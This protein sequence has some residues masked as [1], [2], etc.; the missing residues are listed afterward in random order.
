MV[1]SIGAGLHV[2]W[3]RA[4][5]CPLPLVAVLFWPFR[6]MGKV[7]SVVEDAELTSQDVRDFL[8]EPS[9]EGRASLAE[10]LARRFDPSNLSVSERD[11]A[12][13]IS[14]LNGP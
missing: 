12:E 13:Q 7:G 3:M 2:E 4:E 8:E 5:Q 9:P 14:R 11:T 1:A 6:V 10:K